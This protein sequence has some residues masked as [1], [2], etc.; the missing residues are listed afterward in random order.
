[1]IRTVFV[2]FQNGSKLLLYKLMPHL[3]KSVSPAKIQDYFDHGFLHPFTADDTESRE[4]GCV[5]ALGGLCASL[6]V[7]D[8]PQSVTL[9]MYQL[10]DTVYSQHVNKQTVSHGSITDNL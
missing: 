9:Q 4:E 10:L 7:K 1:M 5:A 3:I 8:P 6:A 2:W